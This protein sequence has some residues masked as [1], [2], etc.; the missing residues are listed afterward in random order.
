LPLY[1]GI[2]KPK[3]YNRWSGIGTGISIAAELQKSNTPFSVEYEISF[4]SEKYNLP[5]DE[6]YEE[7]FISI[8]NLKNNFNLKFPFSKLPIFCGIGIEFITQLNGEFGDLYIEK[9]IDDE[10][11]GTDTYAVIKIGYF[12]K[13]KENIWIPLEF[14]FIYDLTVKDS[15]VFNAGLCAGIGIK[16]DI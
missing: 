6:F 8:F 9:S 11:L 12:Y 15:I 7:S 14:K 2:V 1:Y 10:Y 16:M 13:I 5:T 4:V 3:G